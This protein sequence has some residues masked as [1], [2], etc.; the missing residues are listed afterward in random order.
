MGT[1]YKTPTVWAR[2]GEC[3]RK[4]V[5]QDYLHSQHPWLHLTICWL[6]GSVVGVAISRAAGGA[7]TN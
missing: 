4:H 7:W 2:S 3:V 1:C 5:S 6:F